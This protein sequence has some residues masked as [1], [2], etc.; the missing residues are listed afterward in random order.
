MQFFWKLPKFANFISLVLHI[1]ND[2]F[3]KR[4]TIFFLLFVRTTAY[5]ICAKNI[6]PQC[7]AKKILLTFKVHTET[8]DDKKS[9]IKK[10]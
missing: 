6:A 5:P 2:D 4:N 8:Q 3:N 9:F 1:L 10:Y 7:L